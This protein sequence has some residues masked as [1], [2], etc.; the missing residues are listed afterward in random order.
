MDS[1]LINNIRTVSF[2]FIQKKILAPW[3]YENIPIN[4]KPQHNIKTTYFKNVD[5]ITVHD[6]KKQYCLQVSICHFVIVAN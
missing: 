1:T 6:R 5:C 3:P 4:Q 2:F